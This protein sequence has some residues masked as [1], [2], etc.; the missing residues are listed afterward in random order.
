MTSPIKNSTQGNSPHIPPDKN[1]CPVSIKKALGWGLFAEHCEN[2]MQGTL[3]QRI[4]HAFMAALEFF[5]VISQVVSLFERVVV[6]QKLSKSPKPLEEDRVSL[7]PTKRKVRFSDKVE[8]IPAEESKLKDLTEILDKWSVS[9]DVGPQGH[10]EYVKNAILACY[11]QKSDSLNLDDLKLQS[12]PDCF[13]Y[14]SHL[15]ELRLFNNQLTTLPPSIGTLSN[16]QRLDLSDNQFI[17]FPTGIEKLI[18]LKDLAL[19]GNQLAELPSSIGKLIN[20]EELSLC[21][22]RLTKL[23]SSIGTLSNLQKLYL[24]DN[25]ITTLPAEI[26]GVINLEDLDLDSNE[27]IT[28][29]A[30]IGTLSNLQKLY[31]RGNQ[32]TTL[33]AE[34]GTLYNLQKLYLD[35]NQLTTLPAEIGGLINLEDLYLRRNQL[36]ALPVEIGALSNLQVLDLSYNKLTKIPID[37]LRNM[38]RDTILSLEHTSIPTNRLESYRRAIRKQRAITRDQGPQLRFTTHDGDSGFI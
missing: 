18:N 38:P 7:L 15:K 12:L 16:L 31:L 26:R 37:S 20:L 34:I 32:L 35:G 11:S 5:P 1:D 2:A 30:E 19:D 33:P 36:I 8:I 17:E 21:K 3:G 25:Q 6:N 27:L 22:N 28:L 13:Q 23:P 4:Y 14:L 10:L 24:R 9:K 29:P